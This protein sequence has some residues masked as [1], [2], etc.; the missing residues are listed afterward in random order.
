MTTITAALEKNLWVFPRYKAATSVSPYLPIFFLF[1]LERISLNEAVLLGSA[2][3]FA[4]FLLEVPSG[5]C[6]DKYGRR[7]TLIFASITTALA[8]ALFVIANN[9]TLL[10]VAQTLMA[11]G[12]AFRSGSDSALLFDSLCI[13]GREQEYANRES[14]A[15]KWSMSALAG[16]CLV[17]GILGVVDLRLP[18]IIALVAA[19]AGVVFSVKLAEPAAEEG[20]LTAGFLKQMQD[21]IKHFTH[22]L[23]GW[24]LGFFVV[25][26]SLEHVPY[27]FY[28]PYVKLLGQST[29]T[30]WLSESS[31]PI[32]S[33]VVLGVSMF[34]GAIGAMVSQQLIDRIGLRNLLL[35]SILVQVGI[36]LGLSLV[37]HPLMLML[38]MLRNFSM[39]MA[40]GPM[41]GAIA[42]HV[43]SAQRATLLSMLSLSG[44]AAFS[45]VLVTL[46]L[47]V[48]GKDALNW[49]A[50][51]KVLGASALVGFVALLALYI[52]SNR[53]AGEF[54]LQEKT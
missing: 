52:W 17:G 31:A 44:R 3:Y 35:T 42:P 8:C 32:V 27:E 12:I 43:P 34:G 33:G 9:F 30:S 10:F 49:E 21:T 20:A 40:H 5:Y 16:S 18:Y 22:P 25:G 24:V 13:L 46:S 29:L 36:V 11:A 1:F 38:V 23:L 2:Y 48:V 15:Q 50:L 19:V 26:Y 4:V 37:L 53:I 39:S 54:K 41:L 28:Q 7:P 14:M 47:L 51:S 45:A 6:S